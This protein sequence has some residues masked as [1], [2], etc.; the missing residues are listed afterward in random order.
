MVRGEERGVNDREQPAGE[1]APSETPARL[2]PYELVFGEADFEERVFPR[3]RDEAEER[4]VDSLRREQFGFLS[5]AGEA[6]RD[7]VPPEAPPEALEQYR[8]LLYQAFSF[9]RFGK[10]VYVLEPSTARYLV[11]AAPSPA[12]WELSVPRP[13]IYL[14]LPTNLFWG[15]ISPESTPEPVD[16]F[17]ITLADA[18]DP[19]G[20]PYQRLEVLVVLGIRRD[21]AGF[22]VIPFETEVG[23]GIAAAW[24]EAPGR[25]G[26]KDFENVLPGGELS[27]LYSILTTAEVL[28]LLARTLWYV[29]RYPEDVVRE[30]APERRSTEDEGSLPRPRIPYHRITLGDHGAEVGGGEA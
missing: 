25:E 13:A 26:A 6:V 14:Q 19:L 28:K 3:I 18:E 22:S 10:P 1:A 21:R 27:G 9:W 5:T 11:E 4:G 12:G 24:V 16:G 2:T 8:A 23:A 15:S 30:T 20:E 17:F 7:V 29:E